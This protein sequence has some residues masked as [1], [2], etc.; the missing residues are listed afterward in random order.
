MRTKNFLIASVIVT[1]SLA[2]FIFGHHKPETIQNIV[3]STNEQIQNFKDNLRDAESKTLVTDQKLLDVLGFSEEDPRLYPKDVWKNT[4]M[5]V[6]VTYV[7]EG[8][9]SQAVGLVSNVPR[10]LHN[11]TILVYNLGLSDG[12]LKTLQNYCN[13]SRC[14][15]ITVDLYDFPSHVQD[16]VLHAYRPIVIQD[17]LSR[18]GAI[19]FMECSYRILPNV[20]HKMIMDLFENRALPQGFLTFPLKTKNPVT[21]LTHKKMFEYFRTDAENFQF[22]QMVSAD[23]LFI[24]NIKEIHQEI[25]LPWV[26]C[27]LTQ[28]CIF[29]IGA[30]SAGC[31]FDKKPSYRYSG[32]HYYD[33][34]A[35]NIVLGLKY[36]FISNK[37]SFRK[38]VRYFTEVPLHKA[39]FILKMLDQNTTTDGH[40]QLVT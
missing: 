8:Q 12:G 9:E 40:L 28:D 17:A 39:N 25:M 7:L 37:Y 19:L 15:V 6:I 2:F 31:K 38:P 10:V 4:S 21:S 3:S 13:S 22:L 16:E 26:Q 11:N 1:V 14:Q 33:A 30:Q 18:T 20:T 29:P 27:A 34:S 36:R 32:C 5:P 23:V 24:I 35:L